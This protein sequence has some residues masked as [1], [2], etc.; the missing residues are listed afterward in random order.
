MT[1]GSVS[2]TYP[3]WAT[4]PTALRVLGSGLTMLTIMGQ[5]HET[6]ANSGSFVVALSL[7]GVPALG[8]YSFTSGPTETRPWSAGFFHL[9]ST[10]SPPAGWKG[11]GA[12]EVPADEGGSCT[13]TITDAGDPIPDGTQQKFTGHGSAHVVVPADTASGATGQATIDVTF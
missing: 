1:A 12:L 6:D 8:E 10:S 5:G 3:C 7:A 4:N 13:L 11:G 9:Y 2:A